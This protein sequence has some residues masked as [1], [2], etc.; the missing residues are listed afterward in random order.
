MKRFLVIIFIL[1]VWSTPSIG[2]MMNY[3]FM[4]TVDTISYPSPFFDLS[5]GDN[6][7]GTFSFDSDSID[8]GFSGSDY[9]PSFGFTGNVQI[10]YF[11]NH[12]D[13][14]TVNA[15]QQLTHLLFY[16]GLDSTLYADLTQNKF[17]FS[18]GDFDP[19]EYSGYIEYCRAQISDPPVIPNPEPATLLLLGFGVAGMIARKKKK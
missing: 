4:L 18:G 7:L 6:I 14:F 1:I 17:W 13:S 3:E 10:D 15:D 16:D 9:A 11:V 5:V 2:D 12:L 8:N 19:F